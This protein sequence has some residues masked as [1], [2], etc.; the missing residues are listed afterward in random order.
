MENF[1][2]LTFSFG[3][4]NGVP[5]GVIIALIVIGLMGRSAKDGKNKSSKAVD[6]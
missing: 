3:M 5:W 4:I 2:L 1:D 6:R